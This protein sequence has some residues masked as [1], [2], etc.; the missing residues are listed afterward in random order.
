MAPRRNLDAWAWID[1]LAFEPNEH[2]YNTVVGRPLI[3]IYTTQ[4]TTA[5]AGHGALNERS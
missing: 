2:C 3:S 5:T 4:H 1:L